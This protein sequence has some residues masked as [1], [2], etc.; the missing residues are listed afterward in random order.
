MICR[1]GMLLV[2]EAVGG[3]FLEPWMMLIMCIC[4]IA[5]GTDML[6][7]GYG[8]HVLHTEPKTTCN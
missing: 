2:P 3:V 7:T 1:T 4:L 5:L 8:V 6:G